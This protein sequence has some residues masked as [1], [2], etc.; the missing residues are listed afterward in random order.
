M[1]KH[2]SILLAV[3]FIAI[4]MS[5]KDEAKDNPFND[6]NLQEPVDSVN[7]D[8]LTQGTFAYLHY[9][10]F[11]PT[12]ANSGCHDGTFEHDLRTIESAY[13]TLVYRP[14][15]KNDPSN[16]YEFRVKPGNA[17]ESV[18]MNR[19]TV[20]IDGQSGIMPLSIDPESDWST[21]EATYEDHIRNWI[22]NGALDQFGS[23]PSAGNREPQMLGVVAFADGSST[24]LPRGAG[25]GPIEVPLGTQSLEIWIAFEDDD[26]PVSQ[27][28][29]NEIQFSNEIND[30]ASSPSES[31]NI[32]S[33]AVTAE[34]YF[35]DPVSYRHSIT[36]DPAQYANLGEFSYFRTTVQDNANPPS[37]IPNQGS[38]QYIKEY[39]AFTR[40]P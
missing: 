24:S 5:C 39:F 12:C 25:N 16:S 20:D 7:T 26:T 32:A 30:F 37:E 14:V 9:K 4:M 34:G 38:F 31:L 21:M 1:T 11:R 13:N 27:L 15:V 23:A 17:N 3:A 18:L 28:G 22:N 40:V 36:I 35:G 29:V 2:F 33:Q 6:P 19:L 10:V 8:T